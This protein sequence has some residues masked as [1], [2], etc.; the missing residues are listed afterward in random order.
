MQYINLKQDTQ[1]TI[2]A[3]LLSNL[4]LAKQLEHK[5]KIVQLSKQQ[6]SPMFNNVVFLNRTI[7]TMRIYQKKF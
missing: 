6:C 2:Q 3:F 1:N 7:V 4:I 5:T